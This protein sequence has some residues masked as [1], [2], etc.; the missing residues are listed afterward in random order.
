[1]KTVAALVALVGI[2]AL[3]PSVL[4]A[5]ADECRMSPPDIVCRKVDVD[6]QGLPVVNTLPYFDTYYLWLGAASCDS[7]VSNDC[8]GTPANGAGVT[9]PA[10][11][12]GVGTF[13]MV[14]QETNGAP[15]LQRFSGGG[16]PADHMVFA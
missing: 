14:Y 9:T 3:M 4:G 13:G 8:R 7:A 16:Y 1:M 15:G 12:V 10:G 2:V 5:P 6:H 11:P